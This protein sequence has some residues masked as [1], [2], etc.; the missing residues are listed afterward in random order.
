MFGIR[1]DE[2]TS[3][4]LLEEQHADEL[5]ALIDKNRAYLR[6]WLPWLDQN[7]TVDHTRGFIRSG[8]QQFAARN[9]FH[10]GIY[11]SGALVGVIGLHYIDWA[12]RKSSVGYWIAEAF[13]G[14]GLVT[15]GSAALL[16]YLFNE[17]GLNS[18][19]IACATGNTK[20]CAIPERLGFMK[21]GILRQREWLYD[22]FV[23]HFVY[24]ILA[25]EWHERTSRGAR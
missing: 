2:D 17:L 5:F 9:G 1:I 15:R 25:S 7:T 21:E 19:E 6:E 3:L 8:L 14:R 18:V 22:H 16:D 12:N 20:S 23:D 13:Q 10:C 4:Q 24:N 11:S